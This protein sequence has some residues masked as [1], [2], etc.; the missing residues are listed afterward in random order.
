MSK[1]TIA[2]YVSG[3]ACC[4]ITHELIWIGVLLRFPYWVGYT[5]CV[6]SFNKIETD[7]KAERGL[8]SLLVVGTSSLRAAFTLSRKD[9]RRAF[10]IFYDGWS[11]GMLLEGRW[12]DL[13]TVQHSISRSSTLWLLEKR[14]HKTPEGEKGK[15]HTVLHIQ[16]TT[17]DTFGVDSQ[18]L[19]G[20]LSRAVD[21][22]DIGILK[23]CLLAFEDRY[24][25]MFYRW[26]V[27]YSHCLSNW[28][29]MILR[30]HNI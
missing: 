11:V 28:L 7:V 13:Q 21:I 15:A 5:I 6:E 3:Q 24:S 27:W 25:P 19:C 9:P 2:S 20:L 18:G 1:Q 12:F 26:R 17:K 22:V 23:S 14:I 8:W 16:S 4:S 30:W 10:F 29:A